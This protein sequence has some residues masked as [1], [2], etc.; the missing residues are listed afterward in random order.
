MANTGDDAG[1]LPAEGERACPYPDY[2][3]RR[4][5]SEVPATGADATG[6]EAAVFERLR[7]VD[8][9]EMPVSVIDLGLIYGVTVVEGHATV[10]MTLTYTGCPAR[11]YLLDEIEAA[12]ERADG[13]DAATVRLVWSPEWSVE[14]VTDDGR[15]ALREFG[16]SI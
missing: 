11:R 12:A 2:E 13:V 16:V 15:E 8:D 1:T 3:H 7:G 6:T 5:A 14:L 4:N 10:E 9:P